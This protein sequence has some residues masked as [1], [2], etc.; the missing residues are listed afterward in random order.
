[1]S[2]EGDREYDFLCPECGESLGVDLSMKETLIQR[3]C[4]V[5]GSSVTEAAFTEH[6]VAGSC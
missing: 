4:V 1:M 3:G 2:S 6:S 5:C